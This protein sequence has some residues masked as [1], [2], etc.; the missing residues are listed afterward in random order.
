M[1]R[2]ECF[3]SFA[4]GAVESGTIRSSS[5]R[6]WSNHLHRSMSSSA[7]LV[8]SSSSSWTRVFSF[9]YFIKS[10]RSIAFIE[11]KR[12]ESWIES[13]R[14]NERT[15]EWK[16]WISLLFRP[17]RPN[18]VSSWL[19]A[20]LINRSKFVKSIDIFHRPSSS[21]PF[22]LS[23]WLARVELVSAAWTEYSYSHQ[24]I[25]ARSLV[26]TFIQTGLSH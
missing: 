26:Q 12:N 18:R 23:G 13:K 7:E 3:S 21:Q 17:N 4:K 8:I 19:V 24:F 10:P 2:V 15:N 25:D 20:V 22:K 11:S 16:A 5:S 6:S 1:I 14:T 9:F